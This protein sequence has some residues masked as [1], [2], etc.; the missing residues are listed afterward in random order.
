MVGSVAIIPARS[1]SKRV[2]HKNIR[3]FRGH[4]LIAY[5]IVT[6]L[7]T[8]IFSRVLLSTDSEQTAEIA[9]KYGAEVPGLRPAELAED[10][11]H[12]IGFVKHAMGEWVDGEADQLWGIIRPTSPL[13]SAQ[14][15][16]DAH[17]RLLGAD[18]A[19]S[20]RSLR[21][22]TEHPGK[23]W[24][25]DNETDEALTLLDQ[26]GAFNG[27]MNQLEKVYIQASSFEIVRRG[28]VIKYDSIAGR[29]VL[30]YVMPENESIDINSEDDW[31]TLERA[32]DLNPHLLPT[33]GA[34]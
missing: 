13:R 1:G 25:I 4:P 12:D 26:P 30:G 22:V 21:P 28:A 6:A 33:I 18:W 17:Q 14:T 24:R 34:P 31:V 7:E 20:V 11:A 29:R 10:S 23:M 32:V 27:P 15:L 9:R 16:R 3:L 5:S 2:P 8:G 19:D